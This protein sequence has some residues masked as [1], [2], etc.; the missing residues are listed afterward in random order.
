M[1]DIIIDPYYIGIKFNIVKKYSD[2]KIYTDNL[3]G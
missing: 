1:F 2:Y 3:S